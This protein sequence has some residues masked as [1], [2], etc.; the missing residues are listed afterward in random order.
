MTVSH[1]S[2]FTPLAT[3]LPPNTDLKAIIADLASDGVAAPKGRDQ[4]KLAAI[5][6]DAREHGI[7]LNLVVIQG[8]PGIE[9]NLR[10]VANEVFKVEGGTVA[11]FS[12]DWIGTASDQFTRAKLEWAEDPA[13]YRNPDHTTEAVQIFV[14]RLEQPEGLSWTAITLVL[15]AGLVAVIAGLY[16]VKSRRA[17]AAPA[18]GR[19]RTPVA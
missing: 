4:E 3:E 16:L 12:D 11:V 15:L 9:A 17:A 6:A 10:D 19:P 14:D 2:V 8:N 18:P 7:D 5:V 1:T 13:K